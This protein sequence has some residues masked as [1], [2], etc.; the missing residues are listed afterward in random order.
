M[1]NQLNIIKGSAKEL[2]QREITKTD[3]AIDQIVYQ[4]YG[5]TEQEKKIIEGEK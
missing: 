4:L 2:I 5:I 1:T 3:N